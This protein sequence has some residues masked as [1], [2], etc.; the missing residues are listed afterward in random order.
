MEGHEREPRPKRL[1]DPDRDLDLTPSR[2]H[3]DPL[4]IVEL[5]QLGVLRGY[6]ERLP[7]TEWRRVARRLDAGVVRVEAATGRE[8]DREVVRQLVDG[9]VVVDRRERRRRSGNGVLPEPAVEEQLAGMVFVVA[10][11]LDPAELLEPRVAHS[12]VDG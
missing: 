2:D 10:R 5:E 9:R 7:A 1:I 12:G 4:A 6:V 11:P 8:A 3:A